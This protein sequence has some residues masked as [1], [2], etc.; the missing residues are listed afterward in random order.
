MSISSWKLNLFSLHLLLNSIMQKRNI[1][2][3]PRRWSDINFTQHWL[4]V[5]CFL[6]LSL[7]YI[8][9]HK[10]IRDIYP[11]VAQYLSN[12][13]NIKPAVLVEAR[14]FHFYVVCQKQGYQRVKKTIRSNP[15]PIF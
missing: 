7:Q 11:M 10:L 15:K 3:I 14:F 4:N 8:L 12:V 9:K 2:A 5:L 13:N 6:D 1:Y